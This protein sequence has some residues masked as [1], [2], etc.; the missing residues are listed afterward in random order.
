MG[1]ENPNLVC[2]CLRVSVANLKMRHVVFF[3]HM[4][5]FYN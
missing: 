5:C 1:I 4:V 2:V 3:W